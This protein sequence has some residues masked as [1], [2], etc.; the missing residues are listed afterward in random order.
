MSM[1]GHQAAADEFLSHKRI[2]VAGVSREPSGTHGGNVIYRRLKERG[3]EAFA[4]NPNADTVEGDRCWHDLASIE[5]GIDGVVIATNP[6]ASA[7][8]ARQAVAL[9]IPRI[10]IHRAFGSGSHSAEAVGICRA[11]GAL[12]IEGGCPLMFGASSD[13]GH[14]FLRSMLTWTGSVPRKV[15]EPEAE[16]ARAR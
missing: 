15:A 10:W 12:V 13:G 14:R 3:Y 16:G 9:G 2:A 4:V 6:R 5:G 11:G 1:T 8:A 7:E